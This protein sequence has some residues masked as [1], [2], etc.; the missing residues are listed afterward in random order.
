[1]KGF[2]GYG[3]VGRG[4]EITTRWA[5]VALG[6]SIPISV[7]L[8]SI[9]ALVMLLAW[10][11]TINYSGKHVLS[12]SK[13]PDVIRANPVA[14]LAIALFFFYLIGC[15]HSIGNHQDMLDG[16]GKAA[17]LMF[18]PLLLIVFQDAGTRRRAWYGFIGAMLLTLVLSCLLWLGL[19]PQ[20][21]IIRGDAANP[22]I[23][24]LHITHNLFMAFT[25][26]VCTVQARY[27]A[28]PRQRGIWVALALLAAFNVLFM[29]QGRTGQLVLLVL[30]VYMGIVWLRWRGVAIALATIGALAA[31]AY[32]L[33][34]SHL[35]QRAALAYHE[36]STSQSSEAATMSSSVGLRMEFYRNTLEIV[37]QRPLLGAG[38]GGFRQAYA[39]QV[40]GS[41]RVATHN[42]H[43][44]YLMVAA[45]IG[46]LGLTVLLALFAVQWRAAAQLPSM[47]EQML[48]RGMVLSIMTASAVSS[49]LI[50]HAEGW[51]YVWMSGLLFA[52]LKSAHPLQGAHNR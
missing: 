13:W 37:R 40:R 46:L 20:W 15:T 22:V 42:P 3:A 25:A 4:A 45:Q 1:M 36:F 24:K 18:I 21:G 23:F 16:L 35:H 28:A 9:L 10:L 51:F 34:S 12:L 5:A 44:E 32:A 43:N 7:A 6:F 26:F 8:D 19:L 2:I 41:E 27:A 49:T 29:V 11:L 33:P 48:A 47:R 50:D 38:T 39:E 52:A 31:L 14:W 17:R 30:L